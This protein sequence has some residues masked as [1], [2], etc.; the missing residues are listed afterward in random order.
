MSSTE[1]TETSIVAYLRHRSTSRG[2][3][4]E[5]VGPFLA[6][7][8]RQGA[9]PVPSFA[10]PDDA[11]QPAPREIAALLS[12]YHQR[13]Q[14]PRLRY[15]GPLAPAV[16]P[17][18]VASGFDVEDRSVVM[19]WVGGTAPGTPGGGT[20]PGT[21]DPA[22]IRLVLPNSDAE[23][24]ATRAAQRQAYGGHGAPSPEAVAR[25]R[26]DIEAGATAV[27]AIDET[28]G[29]PAG[30]A[31]CSIPFGGVAELF[32]VAVPA[33]FRQRGIARALTARAVSEAVA[34]GVDTVF[35]V[36]ASD[37]VERGVYAPEGF[38]RV[39]E[40]IEMSLGDQPRGQD[41]HTTQA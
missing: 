1:P 13:A 33:A 35:L 27:L 14:L 15:L 5:R 37:A 9:D 39:S 6:T 4:W 8:A 11:A 16:E 26:A 36:P 34:A 31:H 32:G 3:S 41:T 7:F 18:L 25:L 29:A 17:A 38:A 40:M 10:I 28:S 23:L 30:A 22:G 2:R 12:A 20:A 24:A 19:A 21:P